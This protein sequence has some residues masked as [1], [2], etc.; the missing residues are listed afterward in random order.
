MNIRDLKY[1][2]LSSGQVRSESV[3]Q[4]S[5]VNADD[6][7]AKAAGRTAASGS[8]DRVEISDAARAA[9]ENTQSRELTFARKALLGIPPLSSDRVADILERVKEGYY[10][11]PEVVK[12]ISEKISSELLGAAPA[13]E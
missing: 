1:G 11:Q 2:P 4:A 13:S 8:G 6:A 5:N 3:G 10:S 12:E 9:A 7:S